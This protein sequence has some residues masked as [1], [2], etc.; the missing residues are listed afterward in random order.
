MSSNR[1]KR[2]LIAVGATLSLLFMQL[3]AAAYVCPNAMGMTSTVNAPSSLAS[4]TN[5]QPDG[6]CLGA[7][8]PVLCAAQTCIQD[9]VLPVARTLKLSVATLSLWPLVL[10]S[11]RSAVVDLQLS[12]PAPGLSR[13]VSPPILIRDCC[14]RV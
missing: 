9:E 10:F 13:A 1:I 3:A 2:I 14:Y 4:G 6:G 5:V 7:A 12:Y 8:Q 11:D